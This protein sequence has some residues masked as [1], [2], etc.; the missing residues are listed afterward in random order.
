MPFESLLSWLAALQ[1]ARYPRARAHRGARGAGA[2]R[3]AGQPAAGDDAAVDVTNANESSG[4]RKIMLFALNAAADEHWLLFSAVLSLC[5]GSFIN[6]VVYR[7][8]IMLEREIETTQAERF[9]LVWPRSFCPSCTKQL[10]AFDNIPL[11]SWLL[12]RGRCRYCRSPISVRY[13]LVE[14]FLMLMG[15]MLARRLGIGVDWFFMLAFVA[16]L[17]ALAAMTASANSCRIA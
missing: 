6:V 16:L 14:L 5:V 8:P 11:L 1:R 10:S 17:L 4:I 13:P 9:D 15:I 2:G 12:L 7:L 3:S